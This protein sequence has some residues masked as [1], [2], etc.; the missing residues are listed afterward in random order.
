[1]QFSALA[2]LSPR[3]QQALPASLVFSSCFGFI[4]DPLLLLAPGFTRLDEPRR[5]LIIPE[6][7]TQ[8]DKDK[9]RRNMVILERSYTSKSRG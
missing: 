5:K 4:L 2:T 3:V 8:W 9:R 6:W 1:M 7:R